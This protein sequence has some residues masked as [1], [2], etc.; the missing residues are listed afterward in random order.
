MS[1][2]SG[3]GPPWVL[4]VSSPAAAQPSLP[5]PGALSACD[6]AHLPSMRLGMMFGSLG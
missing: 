2:P 1:A 5:P 3:L 6:P 4:L